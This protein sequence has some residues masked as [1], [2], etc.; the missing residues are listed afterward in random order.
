MTMHGGGGVRCGTRGGSGAR[1]Q[2]EE[3][4]RL[5]GGGV[6]LGREGG[7]SILRVL[8]DNAFQNINLQGDTSR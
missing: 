3:A 7:D 6:L 4:G 1:R 8:I 5:R 2:R